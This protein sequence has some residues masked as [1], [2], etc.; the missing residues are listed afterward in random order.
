VRCVAG[1]H[2]LARTGEA[3]ADDLPICLIVGGVVGLK[4]SAS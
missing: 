3:D 2:A 4:A 1:T